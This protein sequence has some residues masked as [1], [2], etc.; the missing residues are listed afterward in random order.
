MCVPRVVVD[1]EGRALLLP[2]IRV[3]LPF[4]RWLLGWLHPLRR[5]RHIERKRVQLLGRHLRQR[6]NRLNLIFEGQVAN[7]T[8]P[9]ARVVLPVNAKRC[10]DGVT[11]GARLQEILLWKNLNSFGVKTRSLD[12]DSKLKRQVVDEN[13]ALACQKGLFAENPKV[14]TALGVFLY[15]VDVLFQKF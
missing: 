1:I 13:A 12:R 6:P 14:P 4:D 10:S 8:E 15:G 2:V 5:H 7:S 3:D 9:V 11:Q